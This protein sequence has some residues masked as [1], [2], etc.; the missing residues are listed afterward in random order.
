MGFDLYGLNPA[1]ERG[2]TISFGYIAWHP[3]KEL[4]EIVAAKDP[5][6]EPWDREINSSE[7]CKK[8][9]HALENELPNFRGDGAFTP[10]RLV[11]WIAFLRNCGG[12]RTV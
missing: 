12:F 4:C 9:A 6:L 1:H 10:E 7:E 11:E 3:L 5:S 8:L 2:G